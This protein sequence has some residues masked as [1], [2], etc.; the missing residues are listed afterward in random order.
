[1]KKILL[2]SIAVLYSSSVY[3]MQILE[4][5]AE[6]N[7]H[8][9][10]QFTQDVTLGANSVIHNRGVIQ[11]SDAEGVP[12]TIRISAVEGVTD[13]TQPKIIYYDGFDGVAEAALAEIKARYGTKADVYTQARIREIPIMDVNIELTNVKEEVAK[14]NLKEDYDSIE[15]D[16]NKTLYDLTAKDN[17]TSGINNKL[18]RNGEGAA[19]NN[20]YLENTASSPEELACNLACKLNE[21]NTEGREPIHLNFKS[22][23]YNITGDNSLYSDG[24]VNV[25]AGLIINVTNP[26]GLYQSDINALPLPDG[27]TDGPPATITLN[28]TGATSEAKAIFNIP[29]SKV[30]NLS[31]AIFSVSS[32]N[33]LN[34]EKD[35]TLII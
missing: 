17:T 32:Y 28:G 35:G 30:V 5:N 16:A 7:V 26:L 24:V 10:T 9:T 29:A 11:R 8:G 3:S 33:V 15:T 4:D 23:Q 6:C 34:I 25:A 14:T 1:M 20:I 2:L 22:G 31:N 19:Q 12:A 27:D 18:E 21:D 13:E